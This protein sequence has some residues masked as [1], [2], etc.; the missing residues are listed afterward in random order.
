MDYGIKIKGTGRR[1]KGYNWI[2][3]A[4]NKVNGP[5]PLRIALNLRG[6]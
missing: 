1:W 6:P 4:Q 3:M 5:G 2:Q